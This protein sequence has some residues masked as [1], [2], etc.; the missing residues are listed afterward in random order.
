MEENIF[1]FI[2]DGFIQIKPGK[3][4]DIWSETNTCFISIVLEGEPVYINNWSTI[5]NKF[6]F[7]GDDLEELN[8]E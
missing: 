4:K 2:S 7:V 6:V 5:G 1:T 3:S 8:Q